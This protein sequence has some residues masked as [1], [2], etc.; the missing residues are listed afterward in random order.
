MA[1]SG[2]AMGIIDTIANI[3]LV[4]IY[5]KD[6]AVFL[7]VTKKTFGFFFCT[8]QQKS[9]HLVFA[10]SPLLHRLRRLGEP[11][12]CRSLPVRVGLWE[13]HGQQHRVGSPL[14]KPAEKQPH[15]AAQH[16]REPHA[17]RAGWGGLQRALRFLDHGPDQRKAP[18]AALL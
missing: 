17:R 15:R 16:H 18:T 10:G 1:V 9:V 2:L 12:D 13:S 8:T 7:Q 4:T 6:S 11:A 5:Q 14:Q 3:Q